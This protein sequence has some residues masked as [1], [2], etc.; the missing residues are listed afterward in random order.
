MNGP[1]TGYEIAAADGST[2]IYKAPGGLAGAEALA[3]KLLAARPDVAE[4]AVY[5]TRLTSSP[6][7]FVKYIGRPAA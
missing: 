2:P 4:V 1:T 6:R 7:R 3:A 5:V